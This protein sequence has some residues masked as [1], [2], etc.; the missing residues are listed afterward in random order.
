MQRFFF[1]AAIVAA[2]IV[3]IGFYQGWFHVGSDK[4]DGKANVTLSLDTDKVK[5]DGKTAV[6]NVQDVGRQIKDKIAGPTEKSMDGTVVSVSGDKLTMTNKEGK[7]HSHTLAANVIVSCDGK[8]CK[9]ADLK[10]GMRIR[11]TTNA[12]A[13]HAASHIEA[14]DKN[15][16]FASRSHDGKVVSITGNKLVMTNMEGKDEHICTLTADIKVTCDGKV[17]KTADLKPGMRIRVTSESAD[18]HAATQIEAL[19]NDREFKKGA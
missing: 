6:A 17:C 4:A 9:T 11:V 8:D 18:V 14:I 7:E 15:A 16:A 1:V 2:G 19:D 12:L 13:P 5:E 10:P 3:G